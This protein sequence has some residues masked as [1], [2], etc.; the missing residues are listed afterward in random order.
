MRY[1]LRPR[2]PVGAGRLA[3]QADRTGRELY[4]RNPPSPRREPSGSGIR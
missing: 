1:S 4:H 2:T 3:V